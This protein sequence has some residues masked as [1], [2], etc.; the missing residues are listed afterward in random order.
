M[1]EL[2]EIETIRRDLE[3]QVVGDTITGIE[4]LW[5]GA[6]AFPEVPPLGDL[7]AGQRIAAARRR[8]KYLILDL[9]GGGR[10]VLHLRMT[11]RLHLVE[12]GVPRGP[13]LRAICFLASGRELRFMDQRR[14][15]RLGWVPD[16]AALA[17]L[18]CDLGPEPLAAGFTLEV[19]RQRLAGRRGALKPLLLNQQFLA[20]LGNIYADEALFRAR[21]PP[22]RTAGSL[23]PEEQARLYAGIRAALEQ[24]IRNRGT[25]L[26]DYQDAWG[27]RGLNQEQLLVFRRDGRPC[28]V[29]G[30]LIVRLRVGGRSTHLCPR[31]QPLP[32]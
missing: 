31:C 9:A 4:L 14:F 18:L 24:G 1:P 32:A 23:S 16:E 20:G 5:P 22:L 30:R 2:P 15:G 21:L 19:F 27:A 17:G 11:G 8:G 6:V 13:H 10:L 3:Q 25:T 12:R 7:V 26:R 29:C 28:P